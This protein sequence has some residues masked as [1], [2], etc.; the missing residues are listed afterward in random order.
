[1]SWTNPQNP[2]AP[3]KGVDAMRVTAS[4]FGA[5]GGALGMEHGFLEALQGNVATRGP[6]IMACSF[7]LPFPFGHEPAMTVIPNFLVTGIAALIAGL[8]IVVWSTAFVQ[9]RHGAVVLLLL[10]I[11]LLLVG[12]GFG[13]I[14]VLIFACIAASRIDKPMTRWGRWQPASMCSVLG[15]LWGWLLVCAMF[16]VPGEFVVGQVIG[17]RNDPRQT[18]TN[19]NLMLTY[20]MLG[21]FAMTLVAALAQGTKECPEV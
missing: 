16:Y 21:L 10:S 4:V 12:G 20:P 7:E 3:V 19:L 2:N 6:S 1:M 13:P 18:L 14:S 17:L 5:Y 11:V 15:R 8:A 9:K